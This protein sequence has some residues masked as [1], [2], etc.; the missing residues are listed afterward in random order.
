MSYDN[1]NKQL[2]D[3]G[4]GSP[5]DIFRWAHERE[6]EIQRKSVLCTFVALSKLHDPTAC[7]CV[8]IHPT[9]TAKLFVCACACMCVYS[10][11]PF[12][13]SKSQLPNLILYRLLCSCTKSSYHEMCLRVPVCVC[14][15]WTITAL[16][17]DKYIY[18]TREKPRIFL[19]LCLV[20]CIVRD[21]NKHSWLLF[22]QINISL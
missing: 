4:R 21:N 7:V 9:P 22:S 15:H 11:S 3:S 2:F 1:E 6:R 17:S 10:Q 13:V 16:L 18:I 12:W 14:A 5:A 20:T 19:Q 8:F